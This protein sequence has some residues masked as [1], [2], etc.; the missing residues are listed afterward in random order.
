MDH[1]IHEESDEEPAAEDDCFQMTMTRLKENVAQL[2]AE[3]EEVTQRYEDSIS[4]IHAKIRATQRKDHTI[5]HSLFSIC[6]WDEQTHQVWS[7]KQRELVHLSDILKEELQTLVKKVAG[8]LFIRHE[9]R[10]RSLHLPPTGAAWAHME[11]KEGDDFVM[12]ADQGQK[13]KQ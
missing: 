1:Y 12:E 2:E 13:E 3:K 7:I 6:L 4:T 10:E 9:V 11:D 8:V 5:P